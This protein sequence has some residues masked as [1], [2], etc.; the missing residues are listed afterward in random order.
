ML[1]KVFKLR[2]CEDTVF[3]NRT[4]PVCCIRSSAARGLA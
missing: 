4:R 2:T 3:A 1:Q